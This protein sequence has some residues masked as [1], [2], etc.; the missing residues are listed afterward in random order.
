MPYKVLREICD[1]AK[2]PLVDVHVNDEYEIPTIPKLVRGVLRRAYLPANTYK[3]WIGE[4]L[5]R[6][7]IEL[8]GL[9]IVSN[10]AKNRYVSIE[11]VTEARSEES[12]VI[13]K[14]SAVKQCLRAIARTAIEEKLVLTGMEP[15]PHLVEYI[16]SKLFPVDEEGEPNPLKWVRGFIELRRMR[17]RR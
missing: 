13:T 4:V 10:I 3:Y 14:Y 17:I 16:L 7:S 8:P 12:I 5:Q 11:I 1:A 2:I 6:P 9:L 15:Q